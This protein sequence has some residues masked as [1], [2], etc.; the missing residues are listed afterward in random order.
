M[1]KQYI[2]CNKEVAEISA[3]EFQFTDPEQEST[4]WLPLNEIIGSVYKKS[5]EYYEFRYENPEYKKTEP[6]FLSCTKEIALRENGQYIYR[7]FPYLSPGW[8]DIRKINHKDYFFH[9]DRYEFRIQNPDYLP[10]VKDPDME[11]YYEE[12]NSTINVMTSSFDHLKK[13]LQQ[14]HKLRSE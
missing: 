1:T 14:D 8:S 6:E 7:H 5:P 9:T 11:K 2:A 10:E 4:G 3:G 13:L 12:L